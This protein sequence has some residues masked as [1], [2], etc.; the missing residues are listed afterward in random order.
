MRSRILFVIAASIVAWSGTG[1][2]AA[3]NVFATVPEW[4][5][6]VQEIGGDKVRL[7]VAT[8]PL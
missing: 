2:Q 6:L 1:A 7:Y 3:F 4:G 8:G 5:A